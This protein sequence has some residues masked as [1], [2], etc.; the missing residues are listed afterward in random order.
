MSVSPKPG[1]TSQYFTCFTAWQADNQNAKEGGARIRNPPLPP[2]NPMI[3]KKMLG[4]EE[5]LIN[6]TALARHLALL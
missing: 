2:T 1:Y 3:M 5:T 4:P 6:V